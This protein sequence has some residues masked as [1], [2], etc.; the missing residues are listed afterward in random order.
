VIPTDD[1]LTDLRSEQ[2]DALIHT[3]N[4][5][6]P[7]TPVADA[8]GHTTYTNAGHISNLVCALYPR[9]STGMGEVVN[10]SIRATVTWLE[11]LVP[12]GTDITVN[13]TVTSVLDENGASL[14]GPY[15][16]RDKEVRAM[17]IAFTVRAIT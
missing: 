15:N 6:R 8:D 2:V 16:L 4:V 13:D 7:G 10:G 3:C 11:L 14:G 17:H 1:E 9:R 12:L 5:S